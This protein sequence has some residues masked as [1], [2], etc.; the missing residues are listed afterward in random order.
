MKNYAAL[1]LLIL[2]TL[3]F[4]ACKKIKG[5]GPV[6]TETRAVGNFRSIRSDIDGDIHFTP[7][8]HYS[9]EIRA[10]QNIL[11]IIDSRIRNGEL[12]IEFND[13]R[14]IGRHER[15]DVYITAPAIDG[16]ALSGSGNIYA[17]R[18]ISTSSLYL[19]ISGS[20]SIDIPALTVTQ[21]QASI[22]GSGNI[23]VNEGQAATASYEIIGSGN[24]DCLDVVSGNARTN[25]SGSGS[26]RL[27][28]TE[29]LDV[30]ITG[31]GSVVYKGNPRI[32]T[33]ITGS[34]NVRPW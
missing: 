3:F 21:L 30:R 29:S 17:D 27:H 25:T 24:I 23:H 1:L 20:G 22:S 9:L 19:G 33:H 5:D 12:S 10:Q 18:A 11:E 6:V 13:R 34:G 4:S 28:A 31:S 8:N 15:I 7:S 16:F 14:S 2:V 26:T 32:T